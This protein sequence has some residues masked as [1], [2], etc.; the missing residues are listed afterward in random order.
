MREILNVV[1]SMY[2]DYNGS[3]MQMALFFACLIYLIVQKKDKEQRYLFLGYTLLFFVICFC[4]VT[5]K[6]I[7]EV[8]IGETVYWRMFWLLPSVIVTAYTAVQVIMQTEGKRKRHLLLFVML[9]VVG[10]TGSVVY[11]GSVFG[12][13]QNY[14]KLPQDVVDICNMIEA[15]AAEN[16]ITQKKLITGNNLVSFIRQYDAQIL[17]P[18]GMETIRG[19]RTENENA[20]EIFRIMSGEEKDWEALA[21]YAAM[22]DCNYLAYPLEGETAEQLVSYGYSVVGDNGVYGVYRRDLNEESYENSWLIKQYGGADGTPLAF[23]T[24]QD[25]KGH[26]IVIDGGGAEDASYVRKQIRALGGHVDAWIVTHPHG[27]HAGAFMEIYQ[28]PKKI[29]IDRVYAARMPA[30]G[31]ASSEDPKGEANVYEQWQNLDI[32]ELEELRAGDAFEIEGLAIRVFHAYDDYVAEISEDLLNDGSLVFQVMAERESM[33]FCS[34]AGEAVG[35]YLLKTYKESLKSDYI[36]M[37]DHGNHGFKPDFYEQV[38]AKG[39]FFDA[40]NQMM[41]DISGTYDNMQNAMTMISCGAEIYSYATTP[42]RIVL[43]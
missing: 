30:G 34:D 39:A 13:K 36:Q 9:L 5:A 38:G 14:Y 15:D 18:Y 11:N 24:L 35:D 31:E 43:Y 8:C 3:G 20:A 40:P 4:P 25:Y 28:K 2:K 16:G 12:R 42:N 27:A 10:M 21:W 32:P 19:G 23:Y 6:A 7:M 26:L 37:A 1:M 17:M 22:E 29:K 33:L 41:Q